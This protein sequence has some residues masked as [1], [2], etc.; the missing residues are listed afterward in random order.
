MWRCLLFRQQEHD[1]L[2]EINS[3]SSLTQETDWWQRRRLTAVIDFN[4]PTYHIDHHVDKPA[5]STF[6]L[7]P[8]EVASS[9]DTFITVIR[10][11]WCN[12]MTRYRQTASQSS[13]CS[14]SSTITVQGTNGIHLLRVQTHLQHIMTF[15]LSLMIPLKTSVL[16]SQTSASTW[17]SRTEWWDHCVSLLL[18]CW[19]KPPDWFKSLTCCWEK[20]HFHTKQAFRN[21]RR[22]NVSVQFGT[23]RTG[24]QSWKQ[25]Y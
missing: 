17:R 2:L 11:A 19:I 18:L 10:F 21:K 7:F 22:V 20:V 1:Y 5:V 6:K 4:P 14:E 9:S 23:E 15:V 8:C 12:A 3:W 13:Y 24:S 16:L 25:Q